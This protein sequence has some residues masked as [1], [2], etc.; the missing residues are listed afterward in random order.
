MISDARI[1]TL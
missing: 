1:V